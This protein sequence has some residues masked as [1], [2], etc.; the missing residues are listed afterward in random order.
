MFNQLYHTIIIKKKQKSFSNYRPR[1]QRSQPPDPETSH[2]EQDSV[3]K[4]K[5]WPCEFSRIMAGTCCTLGLFN[6]SRFAIFSVYFGANFIV[7]FLILS[8]IFG[9]PMLWLQ[10][11]LGAKIKSGP[12]RMWRISPICKG[13]GIALVVIQAFVALYSAVSI[14]WVLVYFRDSL[15]SHNSRIRWQ[16]PYE[17]FR[18]PRTNGSDKL[19]EIVADYFNG[20]VLQRYQL[21]PGGRISGSALGA[22]RFQV[23]Y[24]QRKSCFQG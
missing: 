8:F 10:M 13:I 18:G 14:A 2:D 6:I 16:E 21:S 9:I 20:G 24:A 7:Q 5:L 15:L 12:I 3:E 4:S 19:S 1:Q 17:N 11:C 22:V 23:K